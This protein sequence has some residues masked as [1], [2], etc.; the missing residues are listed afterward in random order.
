MEFTARVIAD[1]LKG[2]L[3]GNPDVKVNAF[4]KIEEGKPGT[5]TFLAN[6]KYEKYLYETEADIV[7]VNK[8]QPVTGRVKSTLIKVDDAYGAFA[9]LLELYHASVP[10]KTG[11]EEPAYVASSALLGEGVFVGVF[12]CIA[13]HARI[14]NQV[15]IHRQ[16][17]IGENVK[18]GDRTVLYPGV[19]VYRDCV[20]G[21][22][23]ILHSGAVVG[24]DG[25]GFA[26]QSGADFK[27]IPQIGNVVIEDRVEIGANTCIDRAT[28]GST[29]LRR[30]VKL[31][32][33][34][35][36]GHNVEIG[37]NTVIA[38]QSGIS[39]SSKIGPNCMIAGQ[40]GIA[41]H[42]VIAEGTKIGAQSGLNS[43]VKEPNRAIMGTPAFDYTGYM[44]SSVIIRKL[45][46]LT[47]RID[48]LEKKTAV[49]NG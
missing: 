2:E 36:V 20:I 46:E 47:K 43:S 1:Y 41:G 17:Y 28:I 9:T 31:D 3:E 13:E 34:I 48:E 30:G 22:D 10:E 29:I 42:I 37:E 25:F 21:C 49:N 38:S 12:S 4:T 33:L 8:S 23:C 5:L 19:K 40:V 16:V 39:G 6:P 35:Q 24:A 11:R 26:P 32:N 7:I 15:K 27:K 18:I 45:P 14:G 44:K